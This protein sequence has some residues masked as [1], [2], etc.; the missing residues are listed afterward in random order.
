MRDPRKGGCVE[1]ACGPRKIAHYRN[2]ILFGNIILYLLRSVLYI[3]IVREEC[4]HAR[5]SLGMTMSF[6][7]F[8]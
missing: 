5:I 3:W 7:S 6:F 2:I 4:S 8:Y 1:T